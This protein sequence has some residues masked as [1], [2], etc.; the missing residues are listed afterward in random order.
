MMSASPPR[1]VIAIG[2]IRS[3]QQNDFVRDVC[4]GTSVSKTS[5]GGRPWYRLPRAG[6]VGQLRSDDYCGVRVQR[7][8]FQLPDNLPNLAF[9]VLAGQD[10]TGIEQVK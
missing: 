8:L 4:D 9:S 1:E 7:Q 2:G 6:I 10:G 3:V 5:E